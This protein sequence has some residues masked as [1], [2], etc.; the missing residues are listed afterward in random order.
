MR[1]PIL[2]LLLACGCDGARIARE[3]DVAPPAFHASAWPEAD[4]LFHRD[5]RWL[6]ADAAFSIDLGHER[7]LWL[8]GD[9][10]V[11]TSERHVRRESR[12]VR[13]SIALQRGRDPSAAEIEFFWKSGPASWFPERGEQWFWPQHGV[14]VPGGPL[15][16]FF[17]RVHSTPGEG[18]GFAADGWTAVAIDRPDE[19]PAAWEP[20]ALEPMPLPA[21]ILAAQGMFIE[22]DFAYG[23]AIRE[24]GDHAGFALRISLAALREDDL[25]RCELWDGAWTR[26]SERVKPVAVL[27]DAAPESSLSFSAKLREYVHVRSAGFGA[28]TLV[29]E[30]AG[31]IAG[32]WSEPVIVYRPPESNREGAFVYAG[33]AH[34]ELTGADFVATYACNSF[35]FAKLVDD[36]SLYYPRFVRIDLRP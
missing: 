13:N 26:A 3:S 19:S 4:L 14:R 34:A 27:A 17:S 21:G 1:L 25:S 20:R 7:V 36:T 8:F 6:G 10:F 15:I 2:A 16:L 18:L 33:K 28:T 23:L 30:T 24:P 31:R 12:M 9:T 35:D 22:G 29:L 32:P 11:A 5:P